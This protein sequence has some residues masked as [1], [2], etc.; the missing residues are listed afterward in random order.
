MNN[1]VDF[2]TGDSKKINLKDNSVDLVIT[3]A[4][5]YNLDFGYYGGDP[6]KQI[7]AEKNTKQYINS[8]L[9]VTKEM[10]RVLKPTGSIFVCISNT[11]PL[12]SEYVSKVLK[13]TN[14]ILANPP[15]IW[16][17]SENIKE[18]NFGKVNFSYHLIYHFI[19][20]PGLLYCN[21]YSVRKYSEGVW[22]IPAKDSS[23]KITEKLEAIGFVENSF[24]SEIPKRLI[25]MF[26][27]PKD[28]VLDPFGG[29]GTT[30]CE[31]Y[32]LNRNAISIDISEQQTDLAKVRLDLVQ[33]ELK[34]DE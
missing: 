6:T 9:L 1:T 32:L 31:A 8:L 26:S 4:P 2:I 13:K 33:R 17:W 25:E 3:Q 5:F 22:D 7:G 20:S 14:L 16:N 10:E 27:K 18:D 23:D 12:Y 28:I 15:F 34:K 11:E 24:R 21:P 29:S 30:A 19:K